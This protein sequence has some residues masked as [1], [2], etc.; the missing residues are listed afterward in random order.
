ALRTLQEQEKLYS[1]L[2]VNTDEV[3]VFRQDGSVETP[4]SPVKPK[5]LLL[6]MMGLLLG[7]AVGVVTV[8]FNSLY[9]NKR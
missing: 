5:K 9:R 6:V 1:S 7:G 3:A 8:V 4:D 2:R